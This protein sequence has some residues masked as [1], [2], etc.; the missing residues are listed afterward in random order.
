M[1]KC[2]ITK[3]P[4]QGRMILT[5][6]CQCLLTRLRQKP[7]CCA[8]CRQAASCIVQAVTA[9]KLSEGS[10]FPAQTCC[11]GAAPWLGPPNSV[12]WQPPMPT[13]VKTAC[14]LR[15][16]QNPCILWT[17]TITQMPVRSA[18][19][20]YR[21]QIQVSWCNMVRTG[22]FINSRFQTAWPLAL[23]QNSCCDVRMKHWS[24]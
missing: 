18:G 4:R 8:L 19:S 17:H 10:P 16:W 22:V 6:C 23:L 3:A 11:T 13:F 9:F 24:T 1:C 15:I 5:E 2:I 21:V 12:C 14:F 20:A 7:A